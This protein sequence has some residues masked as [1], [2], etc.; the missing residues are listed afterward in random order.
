MVLDVCG[1]PIKMSVQ[2]STAEMK[3]IQDEMAAEEAEKVRKKKEEDDRVAAEQ[4]ALIK[5]YV[6]VA[7]TQGFNIVKNA[8]NTDVFTDNGNFEI[9]RQR[10]EDNFYVVNLKNNRKRSITVKYI[11]DTIQNKVG[12]FSVPGGLEFILRYPITNLPYSKKKAKFIKD[13]SWVNPIDTGQNY[14]FTSSDILDENGNTVKGT[15]GTVV[16][17]ITQ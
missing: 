15:K 13:N 7:Q 4:A 1:N 17:L 9:L 12:Q 11:N 3:A 8:S 6:E 14:F 10:E 5:Q 2:S 16:K